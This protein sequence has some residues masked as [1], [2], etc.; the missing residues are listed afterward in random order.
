M[1]HIKRVSVA[2][3]QMGGG[4]QDNDTLNAQC[5]ALTSLIQVLLLLQLGNPGNCVPKKND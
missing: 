1:T 4:G 3:A 5:G 2:K